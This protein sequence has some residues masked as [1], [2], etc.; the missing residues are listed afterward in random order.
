MEY[1]IFIVRRNSRRK[2]SQKEGGKV[3]KGREEVEE[4][5]GYG[6][7]LNYFHEKWYVIFMS[8]GNQQ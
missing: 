3:E 2:K 8:V 5:K 4:R 1:R 7:Y 6:L